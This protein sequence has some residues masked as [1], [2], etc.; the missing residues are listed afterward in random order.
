MFDCAEFC[1]ADAVGMIGNGVGDG[2]GDGIKVWFLLVGVI[3]KLRASLF[4]C[5]KAWGLHIAL[6]ESLAPAKKHIVV[7]PGSSSSPKGPVN[8][9]V[10][11][12]GKTNVQ[13]KE[14]RQIQGTD[15]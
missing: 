15:Q 7:S 8:S 10:C 6:L 9:D 11:Y 4:E 1:S 2:V 12:R 5:L 14:W 3:G 13:I